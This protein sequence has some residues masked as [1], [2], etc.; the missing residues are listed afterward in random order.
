MFSP[1]TGKTRLWNRIEDNILASY[2][3][4]YT[5]KDIARCF[6]VNSIVNA[7]YNMKEHRV[8]F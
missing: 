5:K 6:D 3:L 4:T 8:Q 7:F 2:M 1:E